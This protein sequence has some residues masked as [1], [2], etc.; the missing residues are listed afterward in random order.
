M[1]KSNSRFSSDSRSKSKLREPGPP[2]TPALA[3]ETAETGA[4]GLDVKNLYQM[5]A[6]PRRAA[7]ISIID[8]VERKLGVIV[9][10]F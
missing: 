10:I 9:L 3:E 2:A 8:I 7:T 6:E 1:L 4:G 5:S